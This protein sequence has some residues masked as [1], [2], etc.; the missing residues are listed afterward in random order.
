ML[1]NTMCSLPTVTFGSVKFAHECGNTERFLV[2][3]N[4]CAAK[5]VATPGVTVALAVV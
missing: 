4:H 3:A 5:A 1:N 2:A